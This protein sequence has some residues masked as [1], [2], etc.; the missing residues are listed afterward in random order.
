MKNKRYEAVPDKVDYH[1]VD[2]SEPV[3]CM[4][5]LKNDEGYFT[6]W[7][8][9]EPIET[10]KLYADLD[11]ADLAQPILAAKPT[12]KGNGS[13]V[14]LK[15]W[16]VAEYNAGRAPGL[17]GVK[18]KFGSLCYPSQEQHFDNKP[19]MIGARRYPNPA[20]ACAP[21]DSLEPALP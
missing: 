5:N 21:C 4:G 6:D 3:W 19:G 18:G 15:R 8:K 10:R 20:P 11:T 1:E 12:Y 16:L 13:Q 7:M 9:V 14:E 2:W 17:L